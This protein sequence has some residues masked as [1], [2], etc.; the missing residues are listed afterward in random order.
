MSC[1]SLNKTQQQSTGLT[2]T[3]EGNC[4]NANG[5]TQNQNKACVGNRNKLKKKLPS[6]PIF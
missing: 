4:L 2:Y 1:Q 5:F 3:C 6:L